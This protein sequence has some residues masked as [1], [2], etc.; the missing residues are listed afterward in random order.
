MELLPCDYEGGR[1][2]VIH[3]RK[4]SASR[5]IICQELIVASKEEFELFEIVIRGWPA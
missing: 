2:K 5:H 4:G 3:L 1:E